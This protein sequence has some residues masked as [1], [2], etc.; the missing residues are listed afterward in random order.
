ML[1]KIKEYKPKIACFNGKAIYEVFSG[2]KEFHFGKQPDVIPG[3]ETVGL[4]NL[5]K[6][7]M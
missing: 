6:N 7:Q 2:Q 1:D 3:T 5:N 4:E